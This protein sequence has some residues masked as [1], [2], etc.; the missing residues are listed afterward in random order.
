M[1]HGPLHAQR[2]VRWSGKAGLFGLVVAIYLLPD[3]P[4]PALDVLRLVVTGVAALALVSG[5]QGRVHASMWPYLLYLGAVAM[6]ALWSPTQAG[7]GEVTI[8]ALFV[9]IVFA[10]RRLFDTPASM[11]A[12][13]VGVVAGASAVL[14]QAVFDSL[15]APAADRLFGYPSVPQWSGYPELGVLAC[16]GA[17]ATMATTAIGRSG[18]FRAASAVLATLFCAAALVLY[19]RL[20]WVTIALVAAWLAAV[21][22]L[23]WRKAALMLLVAALCGLFLVAA[24][25]S[26]LVSRYAASLFEVWDSPQLSMRMHGW[27]AALSMLSDNPFL[28]VGP[29]N[30]SEAYPKYSTHRDPTHAYNMVLHVGAE[31]G[32]VGL[33][34][35]LLMWGRA[36]ALTFRAA[37]CTQAGVLAF[38]VH[39]LL[40]AFFVRSLG[41]QFLAN[42]GP[43]PRFVLLLGVMFGLAEAVG[44]R[45][46]AQACA[47]RHDVSMRC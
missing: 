7:L 8:Q 24:V 44:S 1:N 35:F 38:A 36:L 45:R 42:I 15:Q 16:L 17:S 31:L 47:A 3:S 19:S 9:A 2:V 22:F 21:A 43:A 41:E 4:V 5:G 33:A 10:V 18:T 32:L 30:Y 34:A 27:S 14:L 28:G 11:G 37:A 20:A 13:L 23:R 40:L 29:G 39:G 12:G 6:A 26:R 46:P 25:S